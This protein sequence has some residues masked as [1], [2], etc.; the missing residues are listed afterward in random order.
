MSLA[1]KVLDLVEALRLADVE[2][3]RPA[4]RERFSQLLEHWSKTA[5]GMEP[6]KGKQIFKDARR[7]CQDLAREEK[8]KASGILPELR[9][10]QAK[11]GS[12]HG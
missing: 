8:N 11:G 4:D 9:R 1:H 6:E 5:R 12:H 3:M 10:A 2:R 7:A